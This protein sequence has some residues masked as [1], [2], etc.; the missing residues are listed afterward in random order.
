MPS[1]T[2][3]PPKPRAAGEFKIARAKIKQDITYNVT[4]PDT[5]WPE[6]LRYLARLNKERPK[7]HAPTYH[8]G[9]PMLLAAVLKS[10]V[11]GPVDD[12][13]VFA[14]VAAIVTEAALTAHRQWLRQNLAGKRSKFALTSLVRSPSPIDSVSF[15]FKS[16]A[17]VKAGL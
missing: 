6:T 3:R 2:T 17:A 12:N 4:V 14:N 5:L 16:A 10:D 13:L 15:A 11:D 7:L 8:V 1:T 9:L